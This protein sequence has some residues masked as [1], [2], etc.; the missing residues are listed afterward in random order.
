MPNQSDHTQTENRGKFP[1]EI[2]VFQALNRPRSSFSQTGRSSTPGI[3]PMVKQLGDVTMRRAG[4]QRD[5]ARAHHP[6]PAG[7]GS[8]HQR[9]QRG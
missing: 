8:G 3:A 2:R 6:G 5:G 4:R 1:T 7:F 9:D